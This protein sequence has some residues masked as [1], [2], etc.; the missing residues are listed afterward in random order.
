MPLLD[1]F[2][3][4]LR[5]RRHWES[6]DSSWATFIAQ[7]LNRGLLP[8]QHVAGVHGALGLEPEADVT[9]RTA[10]LHAEL[11]DVLGR[12]GGEDGEL[13]LYAAAYRT[14]TRRK[15]CR[16][17]A[18]TEELTLGSPLPTLPL[19]VAP[20]Q[21]VPLELERSYQTTCEALVVPG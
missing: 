2:H 18:W 1:H 10:N 16:L 8:K 3:G 7:P 15:K 5:R 11:L 20:M 14:I 21:A 13:P 12:E 17:E 19:W 9:E 6:F 4:A